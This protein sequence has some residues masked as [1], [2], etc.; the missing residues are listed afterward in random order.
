MSERK[1]NRGWRCRNE[2]YFAIC[3]FLILPFTA[4]F[5]HHFFSTNIF[6]SLDFWA[7]FHHFF[8]LLRSLLFCC[9][10]RFV[11][12]LLSLVIVFPC[13]ALVPTIRLI[14]EKVH[15]HTHR[16]RKRDTNTQHARLRF[17]LPAKK[18]ISV[19]CWQVVVV[20]SFLHRKGTIR[21][22]A[23][24]HYSNDI[25]MYY[26][27]LVF[28]YSFVVLSPALH[29]AC[30]AQLLYI[31]LLLFAQKDLTLKT[32]WVSFLQFFFRP[33]DF[34]I[35]CNLYVC[36]SRNSHRW[37]PFDVVLIDEWKENTWK[38]TAFNHCFNHDTYSFLFL[39]RNMS[40]KDNYVGA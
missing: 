36:R 26:M 27:L 12:C 1:C 6:L 5:F 34:V 10:I 29:I 14:C 39:G 16:E 32:F 4:L 3:F 35:Q 38:I 24:C 28:L 15:I 8:S 25:C 21:F 22:R 9:F 17:F 40:G 20:V 2:I 18:Q 13:W 31:I 23:S 33:L 7:P 37:A 11:V 30:S 19:D